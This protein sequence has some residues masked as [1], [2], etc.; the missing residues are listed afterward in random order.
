MCLHFQLEPI[1]IKDFQIDVWIQFMLC[2]SIDFS[3][4]GESNDPV[5]NKKKGLD[6]N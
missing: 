1:I 2:K 4:F 5:D 6:N 3:V